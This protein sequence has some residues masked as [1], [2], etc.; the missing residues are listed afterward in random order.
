MGA[1]YQVFIVLW[2]PCVV[3]NNQPVSKQGPK[4]NVH[5]I[6]INLCVGKRIVV[7]ASINIF[8]ELDLKNTIGSIGHIPIALKPL[9]IIRNG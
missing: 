1:C 3:C 2:K 8:D 9:V 5:F 6:A 4:Y 7:I